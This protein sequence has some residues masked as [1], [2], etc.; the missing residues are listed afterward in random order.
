MSQGINPFAQPVSTAIVEPVEDAVIVSS[1]PVVAAAETQQAATPEPAA[2]VAQVQEPQAQTQSVTEPA[3]QVQVEVAA[4]TQAADPA[5]A[6]QQAAPVAQQVQQ[7]AATLQTT[8][9][10]AKPVNQI[11]PQMQRMAPMSEVSFDTDVKFNKLDKFG[12]MKKDE[13]CRILFLLPNEQGAP[14][15]RMSHIFYDAVTKR[16]Y[17]APENPMYLQKFAEMF[18]E[19]KVRFGTVVGVYHTDLQ[20]NPLSADVK[21]QAY[22][23]GQDKFPDLK[24]L[25]KNWNLMTRD[26]LMTCKEESFQKVTFQPTPDRLIAAAPQA[27]QELR[28][29]AEV[30]FGKPLEP[31]LGRKLTEAEIVQIINAAGGAAGGLAPAAGMSGGAAGYNPFGGTPQ[32]NGPG[33]AGGATET[34]ADLVATGTN[35]QPQ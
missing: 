12:Q 32:V 21:L 20:G 1:D 19:P 35:Q 15:L 26:V 10:Q 6:Q 4:T 22:V 13:T 27:E 31:L 29:R 3:A 30:L 24:N 34:F 33:T 23:F 11:A 25:H 7:A 2:Q 9:Q 28:E 16:S 18:G 14:R 17:L 5:P 8:Q